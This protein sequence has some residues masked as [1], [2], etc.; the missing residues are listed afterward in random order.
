M[1]YV[2]SKVYQVALLVTKLKMGC[3]TVKSVCFFLWSVKS[4]FLLPWD[5]YTD[6]RLAETHFSNGNTWWGTMT[7]IFLT[8]SLVFPYHYYQILKGATTNLTKIYL[9]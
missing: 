8:P 5:I 9:S 7:V 4:V 6:V 2:L 1:L 3:G